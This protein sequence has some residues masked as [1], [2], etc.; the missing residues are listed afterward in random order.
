MFIVCLRCLYDE[1]TS[2]D[3]ARI[4]VAKY[5]PTGGWGFLA[6]S[7]RLDIFF[8]KHLHKETWEDCM[9]GDHFTI[10]TES[11]LKSADPMVKD[12]REI[13]EIVKKATEDGQIGH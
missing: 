11:L 10:L 2:F 1:T 4:Y 12:K 9:F 13:L 5:Y 7:D 8:Q 6:D 3:D